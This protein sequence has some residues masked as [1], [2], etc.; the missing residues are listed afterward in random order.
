MISQE[1]LVRVNRKG[2]VTLP[3]AVR[4]QLKAETK[5]QVVFRVEAD[6]ITVGELPLSLEEAYGSV[7]PIN[8][9]ENF[10]KLRKIALEEKVGKYLSKQS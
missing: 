8:R 6:Q 7:T 1:Y 9:P 3:K 10:K 5:G 2:M 4:R